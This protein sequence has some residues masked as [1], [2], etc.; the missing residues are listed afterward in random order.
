MLLIDDLIAT[1]GTAKASVELINQTK[2][3]CVEA[4]FLINLKD[5]GGDKMIEKLT[6]VYSVLEV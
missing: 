5:L 1:G 3:K 4:C 2:A 6:S